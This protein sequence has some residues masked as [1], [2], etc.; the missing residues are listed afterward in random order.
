MQPSTLF[1]VGAL[2]LGAL[3]LSRGG[4]TGKGDKQI[5]PSTTPPATPPANTP[6]YNPE[7]ARDLA[8]RYMVE[9]GSPPA[10]AAEVSEAVAY[11]DATQQ[12]TAYWRHAFENEVDMFS[13]VWRRTFTSVGNFTPDIDPYARYSAVIRLLEVGDGPLRFDYDPETGVVTTVDV[14]PGFGA[15]AWAAFQEWNAFTA[16]LPAR[17]TFHSSAQQFMEA[18]TGL[19]DLLSMIIPLGQSAGFNER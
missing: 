4:A 1:A 14:D 19:K 16:T 18:T 9:H 15:G 17:V 2:A 8:E 11:G 10:E 7:K 13:R 3:M 6:V 12:D 5:P